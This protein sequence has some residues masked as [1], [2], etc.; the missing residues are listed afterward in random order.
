MRYVIKSAN[1]HRREDLS[2]SERGFQFVDE[3]D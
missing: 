3:V 2:R 1:S